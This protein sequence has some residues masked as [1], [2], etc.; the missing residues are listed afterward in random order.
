MIV[1]GLTW[2]QRKE[3]NIW[4]AAQIGFMIVCMGVARW[5]DREIDNEQDAVTEML[6][7]NYYITAF[8]PLGLYLGIEYLIGYEIRKERKL[9]IRFLISSI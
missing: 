6:Q 1:M 3:I 4:S 9:D 2:K 8:V 7:S 5:F